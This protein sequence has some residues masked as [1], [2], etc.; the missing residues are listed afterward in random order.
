MIKVDVEGAEE[1]VLKGLDVSGTSASDA[2]MLVEVEEPHL[3]RF[4]SSRQCVVDL[5]VDHDS[6]WVCWRHGRLE[7]LGEAC[8]DAGRNILALP[9]ARS[10]A[11]QR[12]L[13]LDGA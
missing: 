9:S 13:I 12:T 8:I 10:E 2:I 1:R 5:L 11:I 3:T 4:G 7:T 6:M